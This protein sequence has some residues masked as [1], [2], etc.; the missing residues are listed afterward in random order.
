[1]KKK[2][3]E[4]KLY[5]NIS[6]GTPTPTHFISLCI[7]VLAGDKGGIQGFRNETVMTQLSALTGRS[8]AERV[9]ME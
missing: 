5:L 6:D 7:A 2:Y 8:P 3:L 9:A 1:M 4:C